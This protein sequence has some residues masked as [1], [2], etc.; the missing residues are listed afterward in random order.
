MAE[1]RNIFTSIDE[2]ISSFPENIQ[3]ILF[4]LKA[5]I[6]VSAP[7]AAE[8]ISYAM[9][10]FKLN[11]NLVHFAAYRHHIGFYPTPSGIL[12]YKKELL[13]YK[14]SKGAIQFPLDKPIPLTLVKKIVKFRVKENLE[15]KKNNPSCKIS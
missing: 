2:Y 10:T 5:A 9:P 7:G 12:A 15:K 3:E 8:A 13:P 6:K 1:P 4:K 14:Q 11:G